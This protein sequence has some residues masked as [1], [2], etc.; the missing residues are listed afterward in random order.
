MQR[1]CVR[2]RVTVCN[3]SF[4]HFLVLLLLALRIYLKEQ[5]GQRAQP[6]D[7]VVHL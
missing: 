6:L 1:V 4:E 5:L 2:V 3:V 7:C